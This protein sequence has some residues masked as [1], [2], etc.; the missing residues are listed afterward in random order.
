MSWYKASIVQSLHVLFCKTAK[1]KFL[2]S[3]PKDPATHKKVA[4]V[5]LPETFYIGEKI[6][7]PPADWTPTHYGLKQHLEMWANVCSGFLRQ[8]FL[9][10]EKS[11][12]R[13]V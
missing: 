2:C 9:Y 8:D 3:H 6:Y 11:E 10:T 5:E 13:T 1:H 4:L 12:S 7:S